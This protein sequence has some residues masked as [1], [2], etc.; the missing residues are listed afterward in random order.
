MINI[1]SEE[2]K[3]IDMYTEKANELENKYNLIKQEFLK[4]IFEDIF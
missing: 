1:K 3:I 4:Q 2:S